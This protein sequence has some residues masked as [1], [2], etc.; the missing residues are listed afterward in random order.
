M[1][2][3]HRN[4]GKIINKSLL[5]FYRWIP[6]TYKV[7]LDVVVDSVGRSTLS[8]TGF[9]TFSDMASVV[10]AVKSPLSCDPY[11]F[12]VSI[13]PDPRDLI[14]ENAHINHS[15]CKGREWTANLILGVDA[16]LWGTVIASIQAW[17]TIDH[18]STVPGFYWMDSFNENP[19]ANGYL[20]VVTLLMIISVL[21][22]I[23]EKVAQTLE[24]RKT[25]TDVQ[26]SMLGRYFYYQ[27]SE[28]KFVF[29]Q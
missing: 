13:A 1:N 26:D 21:P 16:I 10:D 18:I 20:P 29:S 15:Y 4:I 6:F 5:S 19:F 11:I 25:K 12:K 28:V 9:V 3:L 14:W 8:S 7:Y 27:V 24:K 22:F 23:F 17:A 2:F